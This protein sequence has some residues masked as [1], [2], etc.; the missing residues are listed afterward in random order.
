MV[1]SLGKTWPFYA[2]N[3]SEVVDSLGEP[4]LQSVESQKRDV[5]H[6][7]FA[8]RIVWKQRR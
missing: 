2:G 1:D 3:G 6:D 7:P 5:V 8:E 4:W